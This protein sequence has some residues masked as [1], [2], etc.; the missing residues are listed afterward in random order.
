MFVRLKDLNGDYVV[1]NSEDVECIHIGK[2]DRKGNTATVIKFK[3]GGDFCVSE[4][5]SED[6][7]RIG[8]PM[9]MTLHDDDLSEIVFNMEQ[10]VCVYSCIMRKRKGQTVVSCRSGHWYVVF[11]T[12]SD[13]YLELMPPPFI[14]V[15]D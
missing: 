10:I 12:V 2:L 9:F 13:I 4:S 6:V 8:S 7:E 3:R 14:K 15:D 5:V 11:E 1:C